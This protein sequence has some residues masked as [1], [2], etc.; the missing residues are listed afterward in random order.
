MDPLKER[1]EKAIIDTINARYEKVRKVHGYDFII[2][3][4]DTTLAVW[5]A[6]RY[7]FRK[8]DRKQRKKLFELGIC[9]FS[10]QHDITDSL[11]S[12][13]NEE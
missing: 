11:I 7:D 10:S 9:D 13:M 12:V 6:V 4:S 1:L 3:I 2:D 5:D 8:N